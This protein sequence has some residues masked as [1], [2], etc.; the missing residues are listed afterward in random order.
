MLDGLRFLQAL[1]M[2]AALGGRFLFSFHVF[3]AVFTDDL[4]IRVCEF[5][6]IRPVLAADVALGVA[7]IQ[8]LLAEPIHIVKYDQATILFSVIGTGTDTSSMR[9]NYTSKSLCPINWTDYQN[10]HLTA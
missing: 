9:H 1:P 7:G 5:N 3:H 6:M 8:A 2:F 10:L 4:V